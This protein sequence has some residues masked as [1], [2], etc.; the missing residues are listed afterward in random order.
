MNIHSNSYKMR[1]KDLHWSMKCLQAMCTVLLVM[2][3]VS[4]PNEAPPIYRVQESGLMLNYHLPPTY[5]KYMRNIY[6]HESRVI[7]GPGH[8]TWRLG[9]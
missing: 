8:A 6:T 9:P 7:H 2:S 1:G 5:N 4:W 3:F